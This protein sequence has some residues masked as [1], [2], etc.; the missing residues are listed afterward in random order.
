MGLGP[1]WSGVDVTEGAIGIR[2]GWGFKAAIPRDSVRS[3]ARYD[4][5]VGGIGVHGWRRTWLVN[6]SMSGIVEIDLTEDVRCWVLGIP[7]RLRRVR[8]SLEEP[9]RFVASVT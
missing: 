1:R 3:I 7:A 8:V 5:P 6:G 2:M 4:G 9:E